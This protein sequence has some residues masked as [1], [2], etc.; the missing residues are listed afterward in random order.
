MPEFPL[1][2]QMDALFRVGVAERQVRP[3]CGRVVFPFR[4]R[5]ESCYRAVAGQTEPDPYYVEKDS[6]LIIASTQHSITGAQRCPL[7]LPK[8]G[9][10]SVGNQ[11]IPLSERSAAVQF[12][13]GYLDVEYRAGCGLCR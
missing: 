8:A 12:S 3:G 13:L 5:T 7:Q 11:S 2:P 1:A 10:G 9:H 4:P 6:R